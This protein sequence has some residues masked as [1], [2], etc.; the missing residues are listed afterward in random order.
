MT[1]AEILKESGYATGLFGKWHN[2]EQFPHNPQ[3]QGFDQFFGFSSGHWNNYFDTELEHNGSTIQTEGFITDVLTK[4]AIRFIEANQEGPFLCYVPYNAPHGPF[5]VP[6]RYFDKYKASGVDDKTAA[7]YGMVEN[8]DDNIGRLL[9]TLDSL[10]I[11]ENTIV[12]F[13]TDNGPNGLRFNG[14]MKGIKGKV[15]EGGVRVPF[16]IRWP[17]T[18]A[19]D[20]EI[21]RIASHIDLLPTLMDLCNIA[22]DDSLKI[23]GKTLVPLINGN[24]STW[25]PRNIYTHQVQQTLAM[26]PGSVRNDRYRLVLRND[27]TLLYDMIEDPFQT[28]NISTTLPKIANS[29]RKDYLAWFEDVTKNHT[30]PPPIEIGHQ[31]YRKVKLPAHEAKLKGGIE[32]KGGMGWANDYIVNWGSGNDVAIW[33]VDVIRETAIEIK[34]WYTASERS[35]GSEI[36]I[37]MNR[38]ELKNTIKEVFDP[39]FVTSKDRIPRGEVY[40]KPWASLTLG[41]FQVTNGVHDIHLRVKENEDI[42]GLDIKML[43]LSA[44]D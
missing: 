30:A 15:D 23:D 22:L 9:Q 18:I 28:N 24:E 26:T 5:Q 37:E 6:D 4:K 7:V 8:I 13:L 27:S 34:V 14:G 17:G 33:Q 42:D 44:N 41:T 19:G 2:G 10:R 11:E 36:A 25:E 35:A 1:L 21:D 31:N 20:Q 29:L 16:F 12:I 32:F 43:E 3:G 40:E 38:Q 39:E